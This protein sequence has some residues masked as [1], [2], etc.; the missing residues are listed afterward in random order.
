MQVFAV[1][2][3]RVRNVCK[4]V[5]YAEDHEQAD[6]HEGQQLDQGFEGDRPHETAMVFAGIHGPR[7]EQDGK[8]GQRHGDVERNVL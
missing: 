4:V 7:A 3:H 8:N 2:T 5:E 6:R 1:L